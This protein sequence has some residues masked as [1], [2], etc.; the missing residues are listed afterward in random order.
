MANVP[1]FD[2]AQAID[3]IRASLT[4][5]SSQLSAVSASLAHRSVSAIGVPPGILAGVP[6]GVLAGAPPGVP[7]AIQ[8]SDLDAANVP[9]AHSL[10]M[11]AQPVA[12]AAPVVSRALA[13][14]NAVPAR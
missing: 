13:S 12:H 14:L 2:K 10:A 5:A 1:A 4:R 9:A 11:D 7:P 8:L 6:P 3:E